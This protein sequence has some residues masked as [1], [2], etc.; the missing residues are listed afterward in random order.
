MEYD[1]F[2]QAGKKL[3]EDIRN[4]LFRLKSESKI[5]SVISSNVDGT[6]LLAIDQQAREKLQFSKV[7]EG[8]YGEC[9]LVQPTENASQ[10]IASVGK[11]IAKKLKEGTRDEIV[12]ETARI[13]LIT[14]LGHYGIIES[15][16]FTFEKNGKT[17]ALVLCEI[18][19][20]QNVTVYAT[21]KYIEGKS[22]DEAIEKK[23]LTDYD[24]LRIAVRVADTLN[25]LHSYKLVHCDLDC[26]NIMVQQGTNDPILIDLGSMRTDA[27][28]SMFDTSSYHAVIYKMYRN[29]SEAQIPPVVKPIF[30]KWDDQE[31]CQMSFKDLTEKYFEDLPAYNTTVSI[32]YG[33]TGLSNTL[34]CKVFG[35][36]YLMVDFKAMGSSKSFSEY[37]E[38]IGIGLAEQD[39]KIKSYVDQLKR[40]ICGQQAQCAS[41]SAIQQLECEMSRLFR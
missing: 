40:K 4:E 14:L 19:P 29:C 38:K 32:S 20:Q 16:T 11:F 27:V 26:R 41:A 28:F 33:A 6:C 37:L 23:E 36:L 1:K 21:M 25:F 31:H 17:Y 15:H 35:G 24:K 30:D 22:L 10:P 12:Q 18:D 8:A 2:L 34:P 5:G 7:G 13:L 3:C 9:F 39:K